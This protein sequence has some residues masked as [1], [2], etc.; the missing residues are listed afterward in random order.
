MVR[1]QG[2]LLKKSLRDVSN[3]LA[4]KSAPQIGLQ[5][6]SRTSV[7]GKKTP[8]NLARKTVSD[9]FNSIK[10]KR[11]FIDSKTGQGTSDRC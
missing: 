10:A 7:K 3:P 2:M 4:K 9:F 11:S 8:E 5:G 6:R 1:F